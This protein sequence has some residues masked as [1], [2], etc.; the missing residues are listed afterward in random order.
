[1]HAYFIFH[2][3]RYRDLLNTI[4]Q[5]KTW[6]SLLLLYIYTNNNENTEIP[7]QVCKSRKIFSQYKHHTNFGA[8]E[9]WSYAQGPQWSDLN[10]FND[11]LWRLSMNSFKVKTIIRHWSCQLV[12]FYQSFF[13]IFT[14]PRRD[15]SSFC[16]NLLLL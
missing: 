3:T 1:M 4:I 8:Y 13:F 6:K 15:S 14:F 9:S 2:K 12:L 5:I 10:K 16:S 11:P 7:K